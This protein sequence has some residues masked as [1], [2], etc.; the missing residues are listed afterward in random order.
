MSEF[1]PTAHLSLRERIRERF[2]PRAIA[3]FLALVI[4]FLLALLLLL[5][6]APTILRKEEK[7]VPLST[8]GVS[9]EPEPK[10]EEVTKA[11]P[12]ART[13]TAPKP[14]DA[15]PAPSEVIPRPA[16]PPPVPTKPLLEMP[17]SSVPD[18][19]S[20]PR[21]STAPRAVAGPPNPGPMPGDSRRIEGRGPKGEPLYAASWY[22][23][24]YPSELNGYL[25]AATGPGWGLINCRTVAN[26]RV[27]DC[28]GIAEYPEGSKIM[29]S[30]LAAAWQFQVRPPRVGGQSRV[31]EWVQIRIDYDIVERTRPRFGPDRR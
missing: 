13:A 16:D 3:I 8:F 23:E 10:A 5:T 30:V 6:L 11:A 18:I 12:T 25:S 26:F 2:G 28:Y 1:A 21:R 14:A 15:P 9:P 4:E 17:L 20:L 24:P 19:A 22:R 31:G 29:R 27:D 7:V